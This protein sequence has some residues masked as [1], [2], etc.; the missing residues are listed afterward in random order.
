MEDFLNFIPNLISSAKPLF[1]NKV[2]SWGF[3]WTWTGGGG[4][5]DG[6]AASSLM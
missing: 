4:D 2:S 6:D 1:P 5:D 3:W